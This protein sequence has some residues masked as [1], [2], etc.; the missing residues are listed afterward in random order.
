[1]QGY[2]KSVDIDGWWGPVAIGMKAKNLLWVDITLGAEV[3]E[4]W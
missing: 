1:M 4:P 3:M 2:K